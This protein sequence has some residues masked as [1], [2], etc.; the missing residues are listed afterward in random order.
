MKPQLTSL[1][2]YVHIPPQLQRTFSCAALPGE[3]VLFPNTYVTILTKLL[4]SAATLEDHLSMSI[5]I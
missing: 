1:A 4:I 5:K 3:M 2:A